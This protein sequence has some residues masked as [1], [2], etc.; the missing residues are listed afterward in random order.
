MSTLQFKSYQVML[1]A[2]I[3]PTCGVTV[4]K[5]TDRSSIDKIVSHPIFVLM[6]NIAPKVIH[7][8]QGRWFPM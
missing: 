6:P 7:P 8:S 5:E 4:A 1:P 2:G 3:H